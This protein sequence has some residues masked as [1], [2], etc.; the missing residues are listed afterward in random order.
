[1]DPSASSLDLLL[2]HCGFELDAILTPEG[3]VDRSLIDTYLKLTP[4]ER[5]N[6]NTATWADIQ[7]M[8]K[9]LGRR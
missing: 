6:S 2:W 4:E 9:A 7:S 1:M 3:G 8:R 5:I